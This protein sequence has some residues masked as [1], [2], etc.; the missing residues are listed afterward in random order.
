[1]NADTPSVFGLSD[2]QL[3]PIVEAAAGESVASFTVSVDHEV[4][5]HY[6][7]NAR[8]LI[9]TFHYRTSAG[10]DGQVTLFI[11]RFDREGPAE[12][13]HYAELSRHDAPI[14]RMYGS[15]TDGEGREVLFLE[16]VG[17]LSDDDAFVLE[18]AGRF[19]KWLALVARFGA[20]EPSPAWRRKYGQTG[21][22]WAAGLRKARQELTTLFRRARKGDLGPDLQAFCEGHSARL[23][24]V[25]RLVDLVAQRTADMPM[26][27]THRD[28]CPENAGVRVETSEWLV[29]DIEWIGLA[30]RFFDESV[31]KSKG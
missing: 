10:D 14:P 22:G 17:P 20:V 31:S 12:A 11:K 6:G 1:M 13:H 25:H 16:Y 21:A 19:R 9:P 23:T 15:L 5:G 28:L 2:D 18:D 3:R 4:P 7:F 26:T 24:D 8:K 29:L 27:L 30:P